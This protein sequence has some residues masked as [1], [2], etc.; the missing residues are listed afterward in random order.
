MSSGWENAALANT[1]LKIFSA[2]EDVS[3]R[4]AVL[5]PQMLNHLP[6]SLALQRSWEGLWG[7]CGGGY[8]GGD[9]GDYHGGGDGGGDNGGGGDGVGVMG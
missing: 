5:A 2:Q 9:G 4:G 8:G 3:P 6:A 1:G 7:A